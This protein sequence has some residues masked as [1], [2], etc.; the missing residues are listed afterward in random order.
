MLHL[1]CSP[2]QVL[3][4]DKAQHPQALLDRDAGLWVPAVC[5]GIP[6]GKHQLMMT[7]EESVCLTRMD[8]EVEL[9]PRVWRQGKT[10]EIWQQLRSNPSLDPDEDT[11]C[12]TLKVWDILGD[13]NL[14]WH[15]DEKEM[16]L[17]AEEKIEAAS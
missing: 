11:S 9:T 13:E 7:E 6:G 5:G 14:T 15:G 17:C 12:M 3:L 16:N 8:S 4:E 1:T 10:A 2:T